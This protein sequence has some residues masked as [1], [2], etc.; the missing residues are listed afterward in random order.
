MST[1]HE[2][3]DELLFDYF[4]GNLSE[5]QMT[6]V[7]SMV[8]ANPELAA[9]FEAW[10]NAFV[11]QEKEDYPLAH[12]LLAGSGAAWMRWT[13]LLLLI[14]LGTASLIYILPSS[15]NG[16]NQTY[17]MKDKSGLKAINMSIKANDLSSTQ[18]SVMGSS[19]QYDGGTDGPSGVNV[20]NHEQRSSENA[21]QNTWSKR[22][23][24]IVGSSKST[25]KPSSNDNLTNGKHKDF[26][27]KNGSAAKNG[28]HM[29]SPEASANAN[30]GSNK[31]KQSALDQAMAYFD[32]G[33]G[34][35]TNQYEVNSMPQPS[36]YLR[37]NN[38][39][40][41]AGS[42]RLLD[43]LSRKIVFRLGQNL[44]FSNLKDPYFFY[45]NYYTP[46]GI[47]P[48]LTGNNDMLRLKFT[49]HYNKM[50]EFGYS[51]QVDMPIGKTG[52]SFGINADMNT[53][54]FS[55]SSKNDIKSLALSGSY[56]FKTGYF[57][58]ISIGAN[59]GMREVFHQ[60]DMLSYFSNEMFLSLGGHMNTKYFY[61]GIG[62]NDILSA[63]HKEVDAFPLSRGFGIN[64]YIGTDYLLRK[65]AKYVL[66]PQ[67]NY[68]YFGS[69][70]LL[71][72][73]SQMKM[74]WLLMGVSVNNYWDFAGNVGVNF[75]GNRIMYQYGD[76]STD[77]LDRQQT[78]KLSIRLLLGKKG[79]SNDLPLVNE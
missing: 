78:H 9:E 51:A 13:A 48:A 15:N 26:D 62:V 29:E 31:T 21:K 50:N 20:T 56:K 40:D 52:L 19:V 33:N 28:S 18:G 41:R 6:E 75:K 16:Q 58:N 49:S 17:S 61:G 11:P 59:L 55:E 1:L 22:G 23:N 57:S 7:N 32:F 77:F 8:N 14:G 37:N 36:G 10:K 71:W 2:N 35:S 46:M 5:E 34:S 54:R 70:H 74:D 72:M 67:L 66:S 73:G 64:A 79:Y 44:A 42:N 38:R 47:N 45:P 76:L 30:R 43:K 27:N 4:E 68:Q 60:Y 25:G 53:I 39:K 63:N 65:N 69:T 3:M 24:G 12:T